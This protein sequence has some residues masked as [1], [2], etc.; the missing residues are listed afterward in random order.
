MCTK[1]ANLVLCGIIWFGSQMMSL[2]GLKHVW[3]F[4]VIL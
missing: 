1:V 2:C 3:L 4:S